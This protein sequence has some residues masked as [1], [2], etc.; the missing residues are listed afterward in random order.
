MIEVDSKGKHY[1]LLVVTLCELLSFCM[2]FEVHKFGDTSSLER[3]LGG[4]HKIG[5]NS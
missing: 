1:F 2:S 4:F 5:G 3:L